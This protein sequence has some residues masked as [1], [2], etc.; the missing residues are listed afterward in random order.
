MGVSVQ[1]LI[2]RGGGFM[3]LCR[4]RRPE[5]VER[6]ANAALAD[7]RASARNERDPMLSALAQ[8]DI[9]RL[10]KAFATLGI[11]ASLGARDE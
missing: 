7:L 11:T 4:T 3:P 9:E 1:V 10:E 5:L 6:V 2:E 8:Q